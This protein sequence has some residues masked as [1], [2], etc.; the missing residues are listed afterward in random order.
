M[1]VDFPVI[2]WV[3]N[4][5]KKHRYFLDGSSFLVALKVSIKGG[6]FF[7]E[8]H[9]IQVDC[10]GENMSLRYRGGDSFDEWTWDDLEFFHLIEG[11]MPTSEMKE[12][13]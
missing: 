8:F 2:N 1:S 3:K 6:P 4:D 10:D 13:G 7:W 11:E 9:A 5:P 12:E